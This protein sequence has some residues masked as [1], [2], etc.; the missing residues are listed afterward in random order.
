[1]GVSE[2][3]RVGGGSSSGGGGSGSVSACMAAGGGVGAICCC[4]AKVAVFLEATP[5]GVSAAARVEAVRAC[6]RV[7]RCCC[8]RREGHSREMH[9]SMFQQCLMSAQHGCL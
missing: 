4:F 6:V 1:M 2:G 7:V 9:M 3:E 8:V 5:P